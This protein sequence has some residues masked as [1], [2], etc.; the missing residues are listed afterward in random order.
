[1]R[2]TCLI[3]LTASTRKSPKPNRSVETM[4]THR[5]V[6]GDVPEASSPAFLFVPN[7]NTT[8]ARSLGTGVLSCEVRPPSTADIDICD[9]PGLGAVEVVFGSGLIVAT[10]VCGAE[11]VT[12]PPGS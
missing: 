2:S 7:L 9:K 1:M 6:G 11:T 5:L 3:I 10:G 12:K 8:F 4:Y